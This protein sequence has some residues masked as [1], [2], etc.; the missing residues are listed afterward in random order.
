VYGLLAAPRTAAS[1]ALTAATLGALAARSGGGAQASLDYA[2]VLDVAAQLNGS[3]VGDGLARL[4]RSS[5]GGVSK[6]ALE[7][8]A[9]NDQ[10]RKLDRNAR[11]APATS[12]HLLAA[13]L[14]RDAVAA[15]TAT[16]VEPA[17]AAPAPPA[18]GASSPVAKPVAKAGK[19]VA[20]PKK[21][22]AG[23]A[24]KAASAAKT[25]KVVKTAKAPAAANRTPKAAP[26]PRAKARQ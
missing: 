9:S 24:A 19:A 2:G 20:A 12:L 8:L 18:E 6:K 16:D 13:R 23:K 10:W 26:K 11:A 15:A 25:T 17:Q 14:T 1:P 4:E 7:A 21:A 22:P 3:G 5:T